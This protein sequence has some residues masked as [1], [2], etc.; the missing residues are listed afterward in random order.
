MFQSPHKRKFKLRRLK[1]CS[2]SS[3]LFI[4]VLDQNQQT[5]DIFAINPS[6]VCILIHHVHG[7]HDPHNQLGCSRELNICENPYSVCKSLLGISQ[8]IECA[9]FIVQKHCIVR[10]IRDVSPL[11]TRKDLPNIAFNNDITI[12][13]LE[14]LPAWLLGTSGM[15]HRPDQTG[16]VLVCL[17]N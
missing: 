1:L 11:R 5:E 8:V 6:P 14:A 15:R 3:Y 2:T 4:L 13:R 16:P 9:H 12:E 10:W 17:V 7:N